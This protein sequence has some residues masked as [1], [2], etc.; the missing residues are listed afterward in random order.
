PEMPFRHGQ[1]L[2]AP[3][4]PEYGDAG[5]GKTVA[6][7]GG[8]TIARDLVEDDAGDADVVAIARKTERDSGGRLRLSRD[9]D[10]QPHRP[11]GRS[12]DIGG[13]AVA[14]GPTQGNAVEQPH[15]AL[16]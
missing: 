4:G 6:H 7:Q 9:I 3:D 2:V 5:A 10:P 1:R 14:P 16:G 8:M 15:H 11:S 12:R 13:R